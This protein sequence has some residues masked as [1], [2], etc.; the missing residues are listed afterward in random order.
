M[1]RCTK[2]NL[3]P[4]GKGNRLH[5]MFNI[6]EG[7]CVIANG[8]GCMDVKIL[9]Q[10]VKKMKFY[11]CKGGKWNKQH[12]TTTYSQ[13]MNMPPSC[14]D[15]GSRCYCWTRHDIVQDVE[16]GEE[17]EDENNDEDEDIVASAFKDIT[18]EDL[19]LVGGDGVDP[20]DR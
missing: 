13:A 18:K 9:N 10:T 11:S 2:K 17:G 5:T 19:E 3:H 7:S 8:T 1:E 6:P 14:T 12:K 4:P 16:E 15:E 20:E